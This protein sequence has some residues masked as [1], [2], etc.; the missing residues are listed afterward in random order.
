MKRTDTIAMYLEGFLA[1][2]PEGTREKFLAK[3]I[4]KQYASI[5]AWKHR[6]GMAAKSS[7]DVTATDIANSV[8][9]AARM[10]VKLETCSDADLKRINKAIEELQDQLNNF[11]KIKKE[12]LLSQLENEQLRISR[13]GDE[14]RRQIDELKKQLG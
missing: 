8:R 12:R 4:N 5:M 11:D 3:D 9:S 6:Q 1:G 14:I 7:S 10:I 2:K 13:E